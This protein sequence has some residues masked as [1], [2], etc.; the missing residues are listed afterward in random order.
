V[1]RFALDVLLKMKER[2]R[3]T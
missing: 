1:S 2:K 3:C